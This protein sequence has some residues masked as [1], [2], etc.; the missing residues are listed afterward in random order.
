MIGTSSTTVDGWTLD[1]TEGTAFPPIPYNLGA[2]Y[3]EFNLLKCNGNDFWFGLKSGSGNL[4]SIK[5]TLKGCGKA[6]LDY[7]NC[8][9]CFSCV[10]P[11]YDYVHVKLNGIEISKAANNNQELSKTV[12]FDFTDGDILELYED[13]L[14]AI[15]FNG[16]SVISCC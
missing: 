1:V 5:T 13:G 12:V 3:G 2:P 16:F 10:S 4:A 15:K 14:S 11:N 9:D 7:G 6:R 8:Y